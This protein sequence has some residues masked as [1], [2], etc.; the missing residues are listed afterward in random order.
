[1]LSL[2]VAYRSCAQCCIPSLV[3]WLSQFV[4]IRR[5]K[6]WH[7]CMLIIQ[8][9]LLFLILFAGFPEKNVLHDDCSLS[10]H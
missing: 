4:T 3:S 9:K 6:F 10:L 7:G 8:V 1:M 5:Y 2:S